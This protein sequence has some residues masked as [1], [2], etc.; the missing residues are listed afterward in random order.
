M[1][2]FPSSRVHNLSYAGEQNASNNPSNCLNNP[3]PILD[4]FWMFSQNGVLHS[5]HSVAIKDAADW[6]QSIRSS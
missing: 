6:Q 4:Q 1:T 3:S 5:D 2:D